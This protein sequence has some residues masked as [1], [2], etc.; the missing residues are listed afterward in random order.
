M[1]FDWLLYF[2]YLLR[3]KSNDILNKRQLAIADYKKVLNI[4]SHY[5]EY[6]EAKLLLNV[7][8]KENND[9]F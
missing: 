1:E 3:G 4:G 8:Y 9:P 6:K 5:P 2:C 7:P